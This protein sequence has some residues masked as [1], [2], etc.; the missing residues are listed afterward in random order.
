MKRYFWGA[1]LLLAGSV[2][3][4]AIDPIFVRRGPEL[5]PFG[6]AACCNSGGAV[7]MA[8]DGSFVALWDHSES[9]VDSSWVRRF[10]ADGTPLA[11]AVEVPVD[12]R[13]FY[14]RHR[15]SSAP[16]GSF[17]LLATS[18]AGPG[19]ETLEAM[20]FQASGQA[21]RTVEIAAIRT[22][23]ASVGHD[24]QGNFVVLFS[25]AS[26]LR[27]ARFD[28]AG[29]LLGSV[30]EVAQSLGFDSVQLALAADGR[31]TAFYE[32]RTDPKI[33]GQ[34]HR[35]RFDAAGQPLGTE[36]AVPPTVHFD[37]EARS[38]ADGFSA[39]V[40]AVVPHAYG[41]LFDAGGAP[42]APFTLW[43][44]PNDMVYLPLVAPLA[45]GDFAAAAT[46]AVDN[47]DT[48][49]VLA[50]I[51]RDGLD[52][53]PKMVIGGVPD[54]GAAA[55]AGAGERIVVFAARGADSFL[56]IY[57]APLSADGFERGDL[58]GWN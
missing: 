48:S 12:D 22:D 10:A 11:A 15:L 20:M 45:N 37:S 40:F 56:Q 19:I 16:D 25:D 5:R 4:L 1:C 27:A 3:C 30:F 7:S 18:P 21:L 13:L 43:D 58:S 54:M 2:P 28:A 39:A 44:E 33:D 46:V 36:E 55:L 52:A 29:N 26:F 35:R 34:L 53:G 47:L 49:L 17:V 31:F 6:M 23:D 41:A 50:R 51:G 42:G 9:G 57:E 14:E 8:A 32:K 38:A 24:G